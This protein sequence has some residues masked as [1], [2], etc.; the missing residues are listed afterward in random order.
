MR[1]IATILMAAILVPVL[2]TAVA[3]SPSSSSEKSSSTPEANADEQASGQFEW[4][5]ESDCG[6]CH[7]DQQASRDD[8]ASL[9]A[10]HADQTCLTCH[11]DQDGLIEA[12]SDVTLESPVPKR[13]KKTEIDRQ[14]CNSCHAQEEIAAAVEECTVLTDSKGTVVNPHALPDVADHADIECADCH[15]AHEAEPASTTAPEACRS[16][17]HSDVYE[18][19]TCHN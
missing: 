16:C 14:Q 19:G 7:K 13:L 3:C 2:A 12:H 11:S 4:T 15:S 8:G 1:R 9:A 6:T 18:C 17:H 5:P 10:L